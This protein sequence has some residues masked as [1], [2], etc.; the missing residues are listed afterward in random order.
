MSIHNSSLRTVK[1]VGSNITSN[2][3]NA[4]LFQNNQSFYDTSLLNT[5]SINMEKTSVELSLNVV[6]LGHQAFENMSKHDF[7]SYYDSM[8]KQSSINKMLA[9]K[10]LLKYKMEQNNVINQNS[11]STQVGV[12]THLNSHSNSHS[13]SN[14][15]LNNIINSTS[16]QQIQQSRPI[17]IQNE[18]SG[19]IQDIPQNKN[20]NYNNPFQNNNQ[21]YSQNTYVNTQPIQQIQQ[22]Q[23]P[24]YTQPIHSYS[25]NNQNTNNQN[26]NEYSNPNF[27][28]LQNSRPIGEPSFSN[29]N[30]N[31]KQ[32][33]NLMSNQPQITQTQI[34]QTHINHP[35]INNP[36][37]TQ[38]QIT[39]SNQQQNTQPNKS[40]N[41]D[42]SYS[43]PTTTTNQSIV[44]NDISSQ[45]DISSI[46]DNYTN[47]KN[48]GMSG[49][50]I[51][52]SFNSGNSNHPI[53]NT[54]MNQ[55]YMNQNQMNQ[56][57]INQYRGPSL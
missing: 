53:Q 24:A 7:L 19:L 54:N 47:A 57:Q 8:S 15:G 30:H 48:N 44:R 20:F 51:D 21:N 27:N 41:I 43:R 50:N 37:I 39:S 4:V 6:G 5:N 31:S 17:H 33:S 36:Q 23:Q 12:Q 9:L 46:I 42:V 45:F 22:P 52:V 25:T 3:N 18:Q 16:D 10:V 40:R 38:P 35:Q 29:F 26:T 13:N 1:N 49:R 11:Q 2:T 55:N 28:Q 34:N 56:N 14:S 32:K